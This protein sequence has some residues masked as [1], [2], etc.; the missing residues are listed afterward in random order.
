MFGV[1]KCFCMVVLLGMI[2]MLIAW[3]PKPFSLELVNWAIQSPLLLAVGFYPASTSLLLSCAC[4]FSLQN[5]HC[6]CA[7]RTSSD[8]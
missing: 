6:I 1:V 4:V 8:S 5:R 3:N 2:K 7:P